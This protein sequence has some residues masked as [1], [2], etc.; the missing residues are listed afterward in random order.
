[1]AQGSGGFLVVVSR[2]ILFQEVPVLHTPSIFHKKRLVIKDF[3]QMVQYINCSL[4]SGGIM[5]MVSRHY[6]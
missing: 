6:H 2:E 1:M 5:I 3:D 4:S